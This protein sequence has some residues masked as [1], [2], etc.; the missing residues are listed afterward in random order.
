MRQV[1]DD[2]DGEGEEE[3]NGARKYANLF[4][5]KEQHGRLLIR[6]GKHARGKYFHI[7]VMPDGGTADHSGSVEVYG[8][9]GGHPGWTEYYGWLHTG[10]WQAD[11]AALVEKRQVEIESRKVALIE[12]DARVEAERK[13]HEQEMLATYRAS[14]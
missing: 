7:Y 4:G 2:Q 13:H 8:I 5:D 11:F 10:P 3:M 9:L 6:S 1:L 12:R 14:Q